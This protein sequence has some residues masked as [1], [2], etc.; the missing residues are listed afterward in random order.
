MKKFD[1]KKI[2]PHAVAVV[3]FLIASLIF[4]KP[5]LEGKELAQHDI[6]QWKAMAQ[7][8]FEYKKT[9]GNFPRWTN[10]M[11]C[12][13]PGLQIAMDQ[14]SYWPVTPLYFS[15]VVTLGLPAPTYFLFLCCLGFYFL[16]IVLGVNPWLG[17]MGG[18]AYGFCTFDPIILT[19]GHNTQILS[20]AYAP[21]VLAG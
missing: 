17:I 5:V 16:C 3:L 14:K 18:I 9:H 13:M 8:S 2:L 21:T 6:Q 11:F 10:S 20:I 7:Q 19:A 4:T 1:F 12:G 15:S